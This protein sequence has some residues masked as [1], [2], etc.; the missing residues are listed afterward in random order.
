MKLDQNKYKFNSIQDDLRQILS[1]EEVIVDSHIEL[2]AVAQ[3]NQIQ[4]FLGL[5]NDQKDIVFTRLYDLGK[6]TLKG[7]D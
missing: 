6:L 5:A 7:P 3:L 4:R 1:Q 2:L